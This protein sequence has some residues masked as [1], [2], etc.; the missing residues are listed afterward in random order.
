MTD[1]C[2]GWT[3]CRATWNKGAQGVM[4]QI[5]AIQQALPFPVKGFDCDNGSEFLN[6]HLLRH[7]QSLAQPV[8]FTCSRPYHSNDS[9]HVE[10]KNGACVR[11]LF[12]YDRLGKT[13]LV[14]PMNDLY[15]NESSLLINFFYPTLKLASKARDGSKWVRKHSKPVTPAQR[16]ID[17]PDLLQDVRDEL[18]ARMKTLNPFLLQ[19]EIQ[20]KLKAIFNLLR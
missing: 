20:R 14:Q 13:V 4:T 5:K 3:E 2:I 17:H 9:A 8:K 6:W 11:Q 19:K 12:G 15:A 10:Q 1:L 7:F 18:Y 16:M